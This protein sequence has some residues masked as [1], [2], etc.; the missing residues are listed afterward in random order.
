MLFG[1]F[2]L[3]SRED[4]LLTLKICISGEGETQEVAISNHFKSIHTEHPGKSH[5]R[6][7][8][9]DFEA[10]G[11]HGVHQCLVFPCLGMSLSNLRD[12]FEDRSLDKTLL[13]KFLLMILTGLD[14][15][16]QAGVVHTGLFSSP[17]K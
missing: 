11:P 13:Q 1:I 8:L 14:F 9:E 12:L 10:K 6:I 3:T 17:R 4:Q 5:M 16:H 7:A 2:A 15:M